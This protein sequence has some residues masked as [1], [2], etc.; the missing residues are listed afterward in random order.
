M[1]SDQ[2]TTSLEILPGH[3]TWRDEL[4]Y[5]L[6]LQGASPEGIGDI[7]LE[8]DAHVRDTGESPEDAFGL[9]KTYA[10][11]RAVGTRSVRLTDRPQIVEVIGTIAGVTL[12]VWSMWLLVND[13]HL[14]FMLRPW[15]GLAIGLVVLW[16]VLR[17]ARRDL[18]R[19]PVSGQVIGDRQLIR[20]LRMHFG[21]VAY[22]VILYVLTIIVAAFA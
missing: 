8:T 21:M 4:I 10:A 1:T 5:R 13:G 22:V 18:M 14:P 2:P 12:T 3:A 19:N 7:L 15:V 11:S 16:L 9:A 17:P 20:D 6:R